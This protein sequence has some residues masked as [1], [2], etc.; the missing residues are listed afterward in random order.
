M[1]RLGIAAV[2]SLVLACALAP[3]AGAQSN[4][5]A[6]PSVLAQLIACR[7]IADTAA[8]LA[9]FDTQS[10]ALDQAERRRDVVVVDR[11]QIRK[12]RRTLFGLELPDFSLFGDGRT[13]EKGAPEEE[14][15][16]RIESTLAQASPGPTGRWTLILQGGARWLQVDT[17]NLARLPRP[18]MPIVIRRAAM[19]S[20]LA[21]IDK[22]IAIRVRRVN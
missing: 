20:F 16:S 1:H 21:S 12:A 19:G 11:S 5:D 17:R 13:N 9:C 7:S 14:G 8:R 18:G 4:D 22:Q 15:V 6:K 2:G 3:P 10:A